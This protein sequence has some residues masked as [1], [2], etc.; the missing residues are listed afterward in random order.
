MLALLHAAAYIT[1]M[2]NQQ[3]PERRARRIDGHLDV[4]SI[5]NTIQGEGPFAGSPAVF[6]RLAGCNL[7]CPWCDTEYTDRRTLLSPSQLVEAVQELRPS[8]P[9]HE[10]RRAAP[11]HALPLV[12]ITGG[13]PFRQSMEAFVR[14]AFRAGYRVQVETNGTLFDPDF[15]YQMA[16]IVC[17]PKTPK[18]NAN[19]EQHIAALKYILQ[20][21]HVAEDGLPAD[22]MGETWSV[23]KPT[24]AFTGEVYVQPLD[25]SGNGDALAFTTNPANVANLAAAVQ[26]ALKHGYRLCIQTHKLSG[27]E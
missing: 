18:V 15:P 21:G 12:V 22:T 19:L 6:I 4:H 26:S 10:R 2:S 1:H 27:V 24:E 8:A 17:S 7:Q 20:S 13:E 16:T 5:F 9:R 3:P 11:D 25:E 23:H 14:A